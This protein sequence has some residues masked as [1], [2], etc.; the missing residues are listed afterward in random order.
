MNPSSR[1]PGEDG[2]KLRE[3][4]RLAPGLLEFL[5]ASLRSLPRKS[6]ILTDYPGLCCHLA[7]QA[8]GRFGPLARD[9]FERWGIDGPVPLHRALGQYLARF[10]PAA[11]RKLAPDAGLEAAEGLRPI[12]D[13]DAGLAHVRQEVSEGIA[14]DEAEDDSSSPGEAGP[15]LGVAL[16]EMPG[17]MLHVEIHATPAGDGLCL[18]VRRA[19]KGR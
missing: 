18:V 11:Y 7:E 14:G 2:A 9:V 8:L 10:R 15:L 6:A 13:L 1:P 5:R 3:K 4:P 12:F 19:S 16:I 17:L